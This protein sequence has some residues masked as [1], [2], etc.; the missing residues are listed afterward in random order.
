MG[1]AARDQLLI[2]EGQTHSVMNVRPDEMPAT[3]RPM[4]QLMRPSDAAAKGVLP[5][6]PLT[7]LITP[8]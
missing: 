6:V 2:D 4:R 3:L 1:V 5:N 7:T 8:S